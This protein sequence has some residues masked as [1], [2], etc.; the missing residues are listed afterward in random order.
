MT[1]VVDPD[2]THLRVLR[3]LVDFRGA[4]VLEIGAGEGRLTTGF[5]ADAASV[6]AI[7]SDRDSI[8]E[9]TRTLPEEHREK[10]TF[11]VASVAELDVPKADFD[12]V[13]FS[14]SL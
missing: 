10:V 7:D 12:L 11:R 8:A 13:L 3:G 6:L 14:W 1:R 2:G 4:R 9:A 5:A